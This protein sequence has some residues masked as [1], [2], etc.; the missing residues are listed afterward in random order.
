MRIFASIIAAAILTIIAILGTE[1]EVNSMTEYFCLVGVFFGA[2]FFLGL[3][4]Y[5]FFYNKKISLNFVLLFFLLIILG[6]FWWESNLLWLIGFF[7][8]FLT[9]IIQGIYNSQIKERRRVDS[10]ISSRIKGRENF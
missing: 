5:S 9:F 10:F 4:S 2:I 1:K 6:T 3:S 8:L 7:G